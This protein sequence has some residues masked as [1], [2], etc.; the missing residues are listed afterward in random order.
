ML[1]NL[2]RFTTQEAF[3]A[4]LLSTILRGNLRV[5]VI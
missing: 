5:R 1:S 4:I 2:T 3:N